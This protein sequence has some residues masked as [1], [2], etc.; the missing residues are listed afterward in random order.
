M[1]DIPVFKGGSKAITVEK[2]D[3]PPKDLPTFVP[4]KSLAQV[5]LEIPVDP[6][7]GL[8]K[9]WSASA[10]S[11]FENCNYSTFLKRV[12][13]CPDPSGPAADRGTQIHLQGEHFVDGTIARDKLP[14]DLKKFKTHFSELRDL[15]EAGHVELEGDWGCTVDWDTTGFFDDNV[16]GRAK[17]DAFV[18]EDASSARVIDYKTGKKFG[19]EIKHGAQAMIY[20]IFAFMRH[21]ELEFLSTEFWYLDHGQTTVQNYARAD[22]MKLLPR[23]KARAVMMTSCTEFRPSPGYGQCTWCAF[24]KVQEGQTEPACEWRYEN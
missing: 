3:A 14:A 13:K 2:V 16:W 22:A 20:A 4:G 1:H 10:L 7:G 24:A 8:V 12:K 5:Q 18:R 6:Q 17:L 23:L 15:Y 19:N 9:A 11:A 21:P